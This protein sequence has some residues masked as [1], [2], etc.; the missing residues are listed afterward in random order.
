MASALLYDYIHDVIEV[1]IE[2]QVHQSGP[3][4]QVVKARHLFTEDENI[5]CDIVDAPVKPAMLAVKEVEPMSAEELRERAH[6]EI[7][8]MRRR[9][10]KTPSLLFDTGVQAPYVSRRDGKQGALFGD[11]G[12]F[13]YVPVWIMKVF[14]GVPHADYIKLTATE[15]V[16]EEICMG[17]VQPQVFPRVADPVFCD[18]DSPDGLKVLPHY[19]K[20]EPIGAADLEQM[21]V[22]SSIEEPAEG[23]EPEA[24]VFLENLFVRNVIAVLIAEEITLFV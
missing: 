23:P 8:R 12:Y 11:L 19:V 20:E 18:V 9:V 2:V 3:F 16:R 7:V 10:D 5:V 1:E 22:A 13:L 24:E 17:N 6:R 4:E 14:N 15:I 21:P